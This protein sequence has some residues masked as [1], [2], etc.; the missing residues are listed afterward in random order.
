MTPNIVVLDGAVVNPGDLS[1]DLISRH[2]QL[3][4]FDETVED[5]IIDRLSHADMVLVNKIVLTESHFSALPNLKFV[6]LLATGY[7]NVDIDAAKSNNVA[8]Y[9]AVDYGSI[10]VAQH[11]FALLLSRTNL[12]AEHNASV[13]SGVWTTQPWCY[14]LDTLHSLTGKT[15]GIIGLGKIGS[16]VAKIAKAFSMNVMTT[17][18]NNHIAPVGIELVDMNEMLERSD[19]I[20]LH[21]PL[22]SDTY[23]MV[24][25]SWL[26]KMKDNA[27]LVNTARGALINELDLREHLLQHSKFTALLDVLSSEPPPADHPLIGLQ[28]CT[29]TPHNA[30]ANI[31]ARQ[32]LL[33]IVGNNIEN[34]LNGVTTN[35]VN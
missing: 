31:H 1:W 7:D 3:T 32:N 13:Q 35:R 19:I 15:I 16:Q 33:E 6:G 11:V 27:T 14:R 21:I 30:W 9:N 26:S 5:Q 34:F 29:I 24:D 23:G 12:I 17:K 28:N 20:S 18:R 25:K 10:S 22:N 2:G 4:V 8:V